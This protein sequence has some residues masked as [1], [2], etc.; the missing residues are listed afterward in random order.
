MT[1]LQPLTNAGSAD[2]DAALDRL[3][4]RIGYRP[5]ALA[6]M[7]RRPQVLG[8][9][10][11]LVEQVIFEPGASAVGFRWMAAYATCVGAG[12][13]YSGTHAAHGAVDAGEVLPRVVAAAYAPEGGS[14]APG[15]QLLLKMAGAMGRWGDR[16]TGRA[17]PRLRASKP[18]RRSWRRSHWFAPHSGCSTGGTGRCEPNSSSIYGAS[19]SS[20]RPRFGGTGVLDPSN[21]PEPAV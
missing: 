8:A 2:A 14:F 20:L 3:S 9:V 5:N 11:S 10:L 7:A 4:A 13:V 18:V 21:P 17:L 16:G 12:C 15:E 6:T 1:I 19:Q